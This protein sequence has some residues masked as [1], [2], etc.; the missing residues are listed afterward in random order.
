MNRVSAQNHLWDEQVSGVGN[1]I[2]P[3]VL[4][5]RLRT[6]LC[7]SLIF[8]RL[9]G[10][11][12][13]AIYHIS[14]STV[15]TWTMMQL[16]HFF[17]L[18]SVINPNLDQGQTHQNLLDYDL[19]SSWLEVRYLRPNLPFPVFSFLPRP[20]LQFT[21]GHAFIVLYSSYGAWGTDLVFY[22]FYLWHQ[23]SLLGKK[24]DSQFSGGQQAWKI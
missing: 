22:P 1:I 7:I 24:R 12:L 21:H 4:I 14:A 16:K 11:E 5:R 17:P 3:M 23:T 19:G 6:T 13:G 10:T 20:C 18:H 15:E 9:R 2:V 8:P